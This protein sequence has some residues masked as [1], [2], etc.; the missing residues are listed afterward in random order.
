VKLFLTRS[1]RRCLLYHWELVM[2]LLE[3]LVSEK[4]IPVK[5]TF[6]SFLI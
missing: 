4:A 1:I 2:T 6:E 5:F 3:C